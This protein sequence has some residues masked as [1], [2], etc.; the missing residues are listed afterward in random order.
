MS[1]V[2]VGLIKLK[3]MKILDWTEE[4]FITAKSEYTA[5]FKKIHL[6]KC[7][8]DIYLSEIFTNFQEQ[9]IH[10]PAQFLFPCHLLHSKSFL[11]VKSGLSYECNSVTQRPFFQDESIHQSFL[12][13]DAVVIPVMT[14]SRGSQ[15]CLSI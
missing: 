3:M 10:E 12:S 8:F 11:V 9:F 14:N 5:S 7:A 2:C 6:D 1:Y 4:R 13:K 15:Q